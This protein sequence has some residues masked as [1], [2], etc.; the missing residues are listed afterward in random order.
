[1]GLVKK[2]WAAIAT[3]GANLPRIWSFFLFIF[4]PP[5]F[6]IFSFFS[7]FSFFHFPTP[8]PLSSAFGF[9]SLLL[10]LWGT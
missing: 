9:F 7:F 2:G 10:T 4:F 3:K 1:M 8:L 5:S 6:F